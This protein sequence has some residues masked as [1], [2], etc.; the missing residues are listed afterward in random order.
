MLA[1]ESEDVCA[2]TRKFVRRVADDFGPKD[3]AQ[4]LIEELDT[5]FLTDLYNNCATVGCVNLKKYKVDKAVRLEEAL[6]G[7]FKMATEKMKTTFGTGEPNWMLVNEGVYKRLKPAF[8]AIDLCKNI[9]IY[10]HKA[11]EGILIGRKGDSYMDS[12]YVYSPYVPFTLTPAITCGTFGVLTRYGKKLLREGASYY[13]R[14]TIFDDA[15]EE[16]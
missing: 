2:K 3:V 13:S 15:P 12:G 6:D 4:S 10:Q 14:V 11:V 5:E 16:E 7:V 8:D 9:S 1:V